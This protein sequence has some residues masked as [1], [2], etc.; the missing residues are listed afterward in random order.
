MVT[1]ERRRFPRVKLHEP[2][3]GAVSTGARVYV[4]DGSLGGFRVAHQ[5]TLPAPGNFVR[6]ELKTDMGSIFVDCEVVRT[7]ATPPPLTETQKPVFHSGVA[8]VAAADRQSAERLRTFF[9]QL[10]A[11]GEKENEH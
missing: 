2:L 3:R 10:P 5:G 11:I 9:E 6:I 7:V 4:L 8:V 1:T